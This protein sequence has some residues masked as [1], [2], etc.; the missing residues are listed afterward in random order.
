MRL[1]RAARLHTTG[2]DLS[3]D[4][5]PVPQF[6]ADDVLLKV[7]AAGICHSD[8]NYREG[9][10]P[11]AKLPITLGHE[12]AGTVVGKGAAV[13]D[14]EIGDRAC[15]HYVIGCGKCGFC[16][17][18]RET[19]CD[20]YRMIGKD[21][22][23]GFAEFASVPSRNV[24]KVPRTV[25]VD[26][27]AILGCAVSTAY[28]ALRRGRAREGETVL[29]NGLG[30]LGLHAV[31]IASRVFR[32][33]QIIAVDV[34]DAKLQLAKKFGADSL[35]NASEEG[36]AERILE[37][38]D[39]RFADLALDFVGRRGTVENL[40]RWI[41]KGGRLV[42]VGI[43][44]DSVTLSPYTGLIG[45]EVELIGVNDHL[46]SELSELIRLVE[47]GTLDLSHSITH[48]VGLEDVNQ[49]MRVLREQT[50][51]PIRIAVTM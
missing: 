50:G 32:A 31:Q 19:Y 46:R 16:A 4:S 30:G 37:L 3:V 13:V 36:A 18:G 20:Q 42:V 12:F 48:R 44:A 47:S 40:L 41:G 17:S 10:A 6:G 25:P 7:E 24:L 26:E 49:G 43:S 8:V 35:V 21:V 15:V 33:K 5:V 23:G 51:N 39:R 2:R 34:S 22:D 28:H 45:R 1:M 14:V 27:A 9:I 11:V 29:V 38:T